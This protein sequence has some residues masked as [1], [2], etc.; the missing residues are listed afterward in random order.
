[1]QKMILVD[2][3]KCTGCRTCELVCSLK[4][5]GMVNPSLS[6]VQV[7][8]FEDVVFEVP[9]LCQQCVDAPCVAVCPVKAPTR[10]E[11][12]GIVTI[13]YDKCIGCKMCVLACPFGAM[14]YNPTEKKVFKCDQCDGDPTCVKFCE[15][16]ALQYVDAIALNTQKS[17]DKAQKL[18]EKVFEV[19]R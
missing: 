2:A 7:S 9:M 3:T 18:M 12:T 16:E 13:N 15:T 19:A 17:R 4:N 14:S 10:D 6:R 8:R 5:E 11:D 1:M